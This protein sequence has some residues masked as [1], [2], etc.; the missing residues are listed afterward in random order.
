M[1]VLAKLAPFGNEQSDDVESIFEIFDGG[2]EGNP[3]LCS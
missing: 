1:F 2:G 3:L